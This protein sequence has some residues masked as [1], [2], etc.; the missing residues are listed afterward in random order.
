MLVQRVTLPQDWVRYWQNYRKTKSSHLVNDL[1]NIDTWMTIP[2]FCSAS[3]IDKTPQPCLS[4][5][6]L[7][8]VARYLELP[9]TEKG[10]EYLLKSDINLVNP[11][12]TYYPHQVLYLLRY[13]SFYRIFPEMDKEQEV[14][15]YMTDTFTSS[16]LVPWVLEHLTKDIISHPPISVIGAYKCNNRGYSLEQ[17]TLPL[18]DLPSKKSFKVDDIIDQLLLLLN[19]IQDYD[20]TWGQIEL[21]FLAQKVKYT[22]Q[23]QSYNYPLQLI[24]SNFTSSG[25]TWQGNDEQ[26]RL[27]A[28]I[29]EM[30]D[31]VDSVSWTPFLAAANPYVD[32]CAYDM[33]FQIPGSELDYQYIYY[34]GLPIYLELNVYLSL[35]QL[36][37][38]PEIYDEVFSD[39]QLTAWFN[40][41]WLETEL[42][43]VNIRL[44]SLREGIITPREFIEGLSLRVGILSLM[45]ETWTSI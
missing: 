14:V 25:I 32:R 26:S 28:S 44:E 10:K 5:T 42:P 19:I 27:F 13:S 40:Q 23:E 35:L 6:S 16:V 9:L 12:L 31:I 4:C 2:E 7:S 8:R 29:S 1:E 38:V 24:L 21:R 15:H 33:V 34:S 11:T 45:N 43:Y 39:E 41:L 36:L 30:G 3:A 17:Y 22:Y 37:S 18:S 20:V